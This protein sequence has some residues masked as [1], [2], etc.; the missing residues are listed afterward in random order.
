MSKM[1]GKIRVLIVDDSA[2]MRSA[3]SRM[4]SSDP[5][6]QV[7]GTAR[8][9]VEAVD[10]TISLRPDVIT[11]DV[12]MPRMNGLEALRLIMDKQP[13][14]VVMISA[15]TTEGAVETLKALELGAVDFIPK[16][17]SEGSI[18]I[19]NIKEELIS[20]IKQASGSNVKEPQR[21][22]P[23][24][25]KYTSTEVEGKSVTT[26]LI[27]IGSSTGGP[28]ALQKIIPLLPKN[29]PVP[30]VVAQHMPPK[31][32]KV[33]AERLNELSVLQVKEAEDGELVIPGKV[34]IAPGGKHMIV[35]GNS[36]QNIKIKLVEEA[37]KAIYKP[38]V[39]MLLISASKIFPSTTLAVIL[40]GMGHDGL[41]GVK[42]IKAGGGRSIV[43]D[44]DSCTIYGMPKA[45]VEA[46]LADRIVPL[47]EIAYEIINS[48]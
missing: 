38:S 41:Q 24:Q 48:V 13:T 3:I 19:L 34:L 7:I 30:V 35:T 26:D 12:E 20:K 33:L 39:D 18:N 14:P 29:L 40:T 6:L 45:I 47:T 17:I 9:G 8:D 5:A 2:F 21:T 11:L 43:Q 16:N 25:S 36:K 42:R 31:F 15:Y 37:A 32:T 10:K 28:R 23:L 27:V 46:G 44:K 22:E 1:N 4:I